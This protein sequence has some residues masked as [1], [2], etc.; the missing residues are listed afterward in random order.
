MKKIA[1][2]R[3][4]D[5]GNNILSWYPIVFNQLSHNPIN[6]A[7]KV[8]AYEKINPMALARADM[9]NVKAVV[10]HDSTKILGRSSAGT[11]K[12]EIDD[13]GLRADVNMGT[14][15]LHRDTLEQVQRGDLFEG[16]FLGTCSN[17][18]D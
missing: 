10:H 11:L 3:K 9:T 6:Y 4:D 8:R 18:K 7:D 5:E 14:T 15:Q 2:I 12:L 16:S 13:Y 17:W 1:L